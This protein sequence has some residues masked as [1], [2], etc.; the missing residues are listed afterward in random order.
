M[1]KTRSSGLIPY[2]V[3][4][5]NSLRHFLNILFSDGGSGFE[6]GRGSAASLLFMWS[7]LAHKSNRFVSR[8]IKGQS[9]GQHNSQARRSTATL[10]DLLPTIIYAQER[11]NI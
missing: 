1:V 3:S 8:M 10:N 4:K 2:P 6:T 5:E 7:V 9:K 11:K